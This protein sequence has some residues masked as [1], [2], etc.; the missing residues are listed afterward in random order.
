MLLLCGGALSLEKGGGDFQGS[1]FLPSMGT[2][3]C[4]KVVHTLPRVLE[5]FRF[6]FLPL[7]ISARAFPS[8]RAAQPW[9]L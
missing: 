9:E 6:I 1:G 2:K 7:G 8:V 5:P 3:C 4:R